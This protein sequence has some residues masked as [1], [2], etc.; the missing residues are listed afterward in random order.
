MTLDELREKVRKWDL[1]NT[2]SADDTAYYRTILNHL[3]YHVAREWR[4]YLPAAEHPEF[5]PR[6][7]ERLATWVGNLTDE[8]DQKLLLEYALH[9][10]FFSHDDFIALYSTALNREVTRWVAA[11]IGARLQP[12]SGHSLHDLIHRQI[13]HH[14]WF[15]PVTDSMDINEFHKVN[16]IEGV[17]YRPGIASLQYGC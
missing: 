13:H 17:G 12:Y 14:T 10:S 7:M 1:Q 8:T 3:D 15:C 4:V 2:G 9:I 6:Y 5:H 16:R 11:L